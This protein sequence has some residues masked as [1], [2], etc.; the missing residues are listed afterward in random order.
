[1]PTALP[2]TVATAAPSPLT[3]CGRNSSPASVTIRPF[4]A[5]STMPEVSACSAFS[6]APAPRLRAISEAVPAP[7]ILETA[8]E[9]IMTGYPRFTAAADSR[10]A[11]G[12]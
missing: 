9:I 10:H 8:A 11:A 5:V 6:R 3:I 12:R 2:S 4:T 1:M 7:I